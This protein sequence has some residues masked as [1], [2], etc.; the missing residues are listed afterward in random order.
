LAAGFAF[1]AHAQ[2]KLTKAQCLDEV[3]RDLARQG[4]DERSI[5]IGTWVTVDGMPYM[6]FGGMTPEDICH[7]A[8]PHIEERHKL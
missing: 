6:F 2:N 8:L 1:P 5:R 4:I 7:V 3:L